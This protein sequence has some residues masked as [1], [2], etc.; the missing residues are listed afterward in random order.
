MMTIE[1]VTI[2]DSVVFRDSVLTWRWY[3]AVGPHVTKWILDAVNFDVDDTTGNPT[4]YTTTEATAGTAA[5]VAGAL[6]GNMTMKPDAT[7]ENH[8]IQIQLLGEAFYFAGDYPAYFG[9][10]FNIDD[11]DQTDALMGLCI[12]DTSLLA[13]VSD[14]IYFRTVDESAVMQFVVENTNVEDT[15]NAATLTDS[16]W[17]VAEFVYDG[18][19][20][21][22]YIDGVSVGSVATTSTSFPDD[23]YL[24]PSIAMLTGEGVAN[25]LTIDW[26]RAIQ[27]HG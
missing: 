8:G 11:A 21:E 16:G 25:T 22:A 5:L 23:E 13:A 18:T 26:A 3:D 17:V 10:R 4:K 15:T 9:I 2:R 24:T 1:Q 20:V 12:T 19:S 14:G 6:G 27:L 7:T